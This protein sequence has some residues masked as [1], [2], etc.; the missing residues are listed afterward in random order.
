[1]VFDWVPGYDRAHRRGDLVAGLTVGAMLIPQSMGYALLAGLPPQIGLYSAVLPLVIY[2]AFGESRQ[3]GVGPTAISSLLTSAG[4]AHLSGGDTAVAVELAATLAIMVGVLRIALG[5]ARLGFMV[6]FLSRPVLSGFTSAAAILI[7]ASQLKHL[8]G[9]KLEHTERVHQI[10]AEAVGR[11]DEVQGATLVVGFCAIGVLAAQRRW[12]PNWPGPLFAVALATLAVTAFQ[13]EDHH[14]SV[15]GEIPG[16]LPSLGVPTAGVDHLGELLPTALAIT[17][18]GFVESIAIAKV[19]AQRNRYTVKPNRELIALGASTVAAGL[20]QAYPVSGSF[21]RTAVNAIS[22]ARTQLAG[23]VSAGVVGL[24]LV[25]LT[26]LFRPMPH[27]VLASVVIMAVA[28]LVDVREARRLWTVK[29]SDFWL[30]MLAFTGTLAFGVELGLAVSVVASLAVVLR[31]TTRPH[32]AVLGRIP[33]TTQFRNVE[34]SPA[35]VTTDGVVVVRVDAPLYFANLDYLREKLTTVEEEQEGRMRVLVLDAT[36]VTEL[37]SSADTALVEIADEL[38]DRNAQLYLA[39]VKGRLLDVMRRSGSYERLGPEHFFLS[40]DD[41]VRH[42]E[43]V[44]GT[45][46]DLDLAD[47]DEIVLEDTPWQPK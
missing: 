31:Q 27:A 38:G 32:I 10:V 13:L 5:V 23:V 36:S 34:R 1:M 7:G 15:V 2:A 21:S 17:M 8:L 41:A 14:V 37:D 16:R 30:L 24:T 22:G 44:L 39:G 20:S 3:L 45:R 46:P 12:L 40:A 6:S 28:G 29:R 43:A 9:V 26:P 35:A 25:A 33:G 47:K 42:A 18:L 11:I 4:L 19:F